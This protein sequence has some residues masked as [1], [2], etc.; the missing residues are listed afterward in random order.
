MLPLASMLRR[1]KTDSEITYFSYI[2]NRLDL[3]TTTLSPKHQ[4][5]LIT[6]IKAC[7]HALRDI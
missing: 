5:P 4:R 7:R 3:E 2:P 6:L 1:V